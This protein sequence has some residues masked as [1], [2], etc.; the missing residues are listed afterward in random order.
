[1][2]LL[3]I[4]ADSSLCIR[5]SKHGSRLCCRIPTCEPNR[6]GPGNTGQEGALQRGW[7]KEW[8]GAQERVEK[9]LLLQPQALGH[10]RHV[11]CSHTA[12]G[13]KHSTI[14]SIFTLNLKHKS[15]RASEHLSAIKTPETSQTLQMPQVQPRPTPPPPPPQKK[16][17]KNNS[18]PLRG[19]QAFASSVPHEA[20][21]LLVGLKWT[22]GICRFP[23][24]HEIQNRVYIDIGIIPP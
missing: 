3:L 2:K 18:L 8:E 19:V 16:R 20:R 1:M 23:T 9:E 12:R 24:S 22:S 7:V 10:D 6:L 15:A 5:P 4:E 11:H 14:K 13:P 17:D 21:C